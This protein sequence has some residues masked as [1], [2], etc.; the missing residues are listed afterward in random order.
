MPCFD[1]DPPVLAVD[2]GTSNTALAVLETGQPPRRIAIEDGQD[3]LPTAVF[4]PTEG[5]G[6]C[7]SVA[8]PVPR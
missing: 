3:T 6:G 8:A 2:F 5:G 1:R 4:F 7:R